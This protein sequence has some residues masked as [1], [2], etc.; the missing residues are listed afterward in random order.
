MAYETLKAF[1]GNK[2]IFVGEGK[3]GCTGCDNFFQ[4]LEKNW[5][6]TDYI[7]IPHWLGM[8]DSLMFFVR[9]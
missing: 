8:H 1:K 7:S 3:G 9:K 5:T 2:I 4:E 6:E